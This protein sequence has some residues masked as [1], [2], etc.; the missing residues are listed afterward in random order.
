METRLRFLLG[1]LCANASL[2]TLTALACAALVNENWNPL[3][4]M[5]VGMLLGMLLAAVQGSARG[6]AVSVNGVGAGLA[7]CLQARVDEAGG[8]PEE[9]PAAPAP[10]E[11]AAAE[12]A[13]AEEAP[14]EEAPA[15]AAP[16]EEPEKN[17]ESSA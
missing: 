10:A 6:L 3:L 5:L 15:D 9:A 7:R 17:E 4:A 2:G 11:E 16:A 8:A 14:A 13:P 12:E 1:D